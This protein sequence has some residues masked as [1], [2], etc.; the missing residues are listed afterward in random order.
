[1][2][3]LTMVLLVLLGAAT[4]GIYLLAQEQAPQKDATP[5]DGGYLIPLHGPLSFDDKPCGKFF[6]LK[7]FGQGP[8]LMF[9]FR[10]AQKG[11][12]NVHTR[13]NQLIVLVNWRSKVVRARADVVQEGPLAHVVIEISPADFEK[14]KS[15]TEGFE[16]RHLV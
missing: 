10:D 16:V 15:C 11:A 4:Y 8:D 14:M 5:G 6:E 3:K 13:P 7:Q 12:L 1:M 2:R 9:E